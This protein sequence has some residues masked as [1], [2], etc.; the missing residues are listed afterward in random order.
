MT[1]EHNSWGESAEGL[2]VTLISCIRCSISM[3]TSL[4]SGV[5]ELPQTLYTGSISYL[6]WY[7]H[8]KICGGLLVWVGLLYTHI[9]SQKIQCIFLFYQVLFEGSYPYNTPSDRLLYCPQQT[10]LRHFITFLEV[11]IQSF[12]YW[13]PYR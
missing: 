10:L 4:L 11:I 9:D 2:I 7:L 13:T 5:L 6:S 3:S 12:S 1:K 8:R